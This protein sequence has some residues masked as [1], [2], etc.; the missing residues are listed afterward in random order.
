MP[1]K[2]ESLIIEG[3]MSPIVFAAPSAIQKRDELLAAA[4]TV[5]LV[6]DADSAEVAVDM[7][8]QLKEFT[9]AIEASR[10][11]VKAPIDLV[12]ANIQLI[13]KTLTQVVAT[14]S[15]RIDRMVGDWNTEQQRLAQIERQKAIDEENRII[16]EANQ[17]MEDA[18]AAGK[19]DKQIEKIESKAFTQLATAKA[20]TAAIA[21]PKFTGTA[22]RGDVEFEVTDIQALYAAHPMMVK[23]EPISSLIKAAL[24]N[25]TVLPGVTSRNVSRT[26]I[27]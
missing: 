25:G 12:V 7:L 21:A 6:K 11:E 10:K 18:A 2:I 9:R 8:K 4:K 13:A 20:T 15:E 22:T 5:K 27:R 19:T 16:A 24:K 14:E 23:L 1:T 3:I 17:K 26:I